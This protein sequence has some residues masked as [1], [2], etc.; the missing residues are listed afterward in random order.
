MKIVY[1]YPMFMDL[2]EPNGALTLD[3]RSHACWDYTR[4]AMRA[5]ELHAGGIE[6]QVIQYKVGSSISEMPHWHESRDEEI[7]RSVALIYG[8]TDPSEFLKDDFKKRAW[9]Q[10]KMLGLHVELEIYNVRPGARRLH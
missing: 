6:N 3:K 8:L 4:K 2:L 5:R 9:T 7:A 10:A 1:E